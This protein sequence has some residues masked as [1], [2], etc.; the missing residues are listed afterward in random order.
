MEQP[1]VLKTDEVVPWAWGRGN[2]VWAMFQ[3]ASEGDVD[4]LKQLVAKDAG[5]VRSW[6]NYEN[7]VHV[8]VRTNQLDATAWL[9]NHGSDV[10]SFCCPLSQHSLL[11]IA[12]SGG[13]D[14][15]IE[16]LAIHLND[17]FGIGTAGEEIA[18]AIREQDASRFAA[19]I[20]EHGVHV[21][22]RYGNQPLHWAVMTGQIPLVDELL[23]QGADI[24]AMRPD[25]ARPVDL[26]NGDHIHRGTHP[27]ATTEHWQ[28]IVHLLACGADCQLT[29]ACRLGDLNRAQ[30]IL[31]N[32]PQQANAD[33]PY[34]TWN[35]GQPL[36]N[37][38]LAGH[39]EVTQL[40]LEAGADPNKP[41]P[42]L[43]PWGAALHDAVWSNHPDVTRLLLKHRA[44]PNQE[45]ESC[46]NVLY[47]AD[48]A[49]VDN[50]LRQLLVEAGAA[51][52][53]PDEQ[54]EERSRIAN[55]TAP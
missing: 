16:L 45:M 7:P 15:M 41:E 32:D 5:L 11:E 52:F 43:A 25:G 34:H 30:E 27:R 22:D 54:V 20:S 35:F 10:A 14:A 1:D 38:A 6:H 48:H 51:E 42:G 53:L 17:R 37:A 46:A 40:L 55:S 13:H 8:A 2:D 31:T 33:V 44:N 47:V 21:S 50:E 28:I 24:N 3:S 26:S 36:R 12:E 39:L 23:S 4:Q 18:E 49:G 29:T 19:F 9:L